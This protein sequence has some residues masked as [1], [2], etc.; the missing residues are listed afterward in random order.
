METPRSDHN[1]DPTAPDSGE[2]LT[3]DEDTGET[4]VFCLYLAGNTIRSKMALRQLKSI[5]SQYLPDRHEI[6]VIDV[7]KNP[8]LAEAA[9]IIATPTLVKELPPP[10]RKFIGDL[11][12]KERILI[13][14]ELI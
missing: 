8:E 1:P 14:L 7:Y 13:G 4:Y 5:C 12:E 11:S 9:Q 6:R 10:L 2:N 3:L